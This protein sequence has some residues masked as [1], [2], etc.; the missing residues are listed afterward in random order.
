VLYFLP[1][2]LS[3]C[4]SAQIV[5]SDSSSIVIEPA[6][7]IY[8]PSKGCIAPPCTPVKVYDEITP[9]PPP[10]IP[11]RSE[12][13]GH[14]VI[15]VVGERYKIGSSSAEFWVLTASTPNPAWL[16]QALMHAPLAIQRWRSAAAHRESTIEEGYIVY[17]EI[18]SVVGHH[19]FHS[20]RG[21]GRHY[22]VQYAAEPTL[23]DL[24]HENRLLRHGR[25]LIDTYNAT[26]ARK[27]DTDS[28]VARILRN[29]GKR[30]RLRPRSVSPSACKSYTTFHCLIIAT[31][32]LALICVWVSSYRIIRTLRISRTE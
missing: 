14:E 19:D 32:T 23:Q 5:M 2:R 29:S 18:T 17:R 10:E 31:L 11:S 4:L 25:V 9:F 13:L 1:H 15:S 3:L 30:P 8:I 12:S 26:L 24:I 20:L 16:P 27:D 22:F 7:P 21:T 28:E 6:S